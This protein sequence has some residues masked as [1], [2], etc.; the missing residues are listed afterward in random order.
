MILEVGRLYLGNR[1]LGGVG[2]G[3]SEGPGGDVSSLLVFQRKILR[4]LEIWEATTYEALRSIGAEFHVL[5]C[6]L[7]FYRINDMADGARRDV[8]SEVS[9]IMLR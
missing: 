2:G 7:R 9:I 6:R 3:R 1:R 8:F 5:V 4:F